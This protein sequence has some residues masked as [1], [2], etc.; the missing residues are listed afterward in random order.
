MMAQQYYFDHNATTP[1]RPEVIEAML[2]YLAEKFGNASSVHSFGRKAKQALDESRVEVARLIGAEPAEIYFTGC[3]TESD[4][5]AL[6]GC[7]TAREDGRR[8][9]VTTS[10][11]H[12]AIINSAKSF[13]P[14]WI[15]RRNDF[16]STVKTCFPLGDEHQNVLKLCL[17]RRDI[18]ILRGSAFWV[19]NRSFTIVKATRK[20]IFLLKKRS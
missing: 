10:V 19:E 6:I 12:S 7:L 1:V 16:L 13:T 15:L 8:G 9:L 14:D 2:P 3:G 11:E 20:G 4:N 18:F 5:I 17:T